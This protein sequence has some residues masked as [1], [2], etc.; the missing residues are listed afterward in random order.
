MDYD[1]IVIG[2]G[3][4]GLMSALYMKRFRRDV[5]LINDGKSRAAWIPKTRNILGFPDGITGREIINRLNRHITKHGVERLYAHAVVKRTRGALSVDCDNVSFKTKTVILATGIKDIQP[6]I[7]NLNQLR[8]SGLLRYC[9]VCDAYDYRDQIIGVIANAKSGIE[10]ALWLSRFTSKLRLFLPRELVITRQHSR[11]LRL[12]RITLYRRHISS[13]ELARAP[14][15]LWVHG[16]GAKPVYCR[17]IYPMLG[18]E[19]NDSAFRTLKDL[20][21]SEEGFIIT[22]TEQR[23]SIPRVFAVGDCVNLLAQISV[24]AGQAAI[25]ATTAHNDLL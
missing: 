18:C 10:K 5:L 13:I 12:A 23:T 8:A 17:V 15:G 20:K 14:I 4:G 22:D 7:S 21:K 24:A 2:G 25:A 3:P 11:E 9:P 19:V 16:H 6:Q 1:C